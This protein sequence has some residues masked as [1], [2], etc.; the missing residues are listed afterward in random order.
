MP[1]Y[2]FIC[3]SCHYEQTDVFIKAE[4]LKKKVWQPK[5]DNCQQIMEVVFKKAPGVIW[6]GEAPPGQQSKNARAADKA[7]EIFE[8]GFTSQQELQESMEMAKEE[9]KKR[10][11]PEGL[12]TTGVKNPTTKEDAEKVRKRASDKAKAS[13]KARGD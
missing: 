10:E 7:M 1:R 4:E 3:S 13:R 5:C 12:L 6:K 8:E 9:E 2:D 11:K